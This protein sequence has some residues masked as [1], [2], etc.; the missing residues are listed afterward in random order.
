MLLLG[1]GTGADLPLLQ[2]DENCTCERVYA[3][4]YSS[5]MVKQCRKRARECGIP[6]DNVMQGDAQDLPFEEGVVFDKVL[7]PLS[8]GS[9]PQPEEAMR[10]ALRVLAPGGRVCVLEKLVDSNSTPS[11]ARK[12]IGCVTK[13]LFSDINRSLEDMLVLTPELKVVEYK[14]MAGLISGCF[15]MSADKYR[16]AVLVRRSDYPDLTEVE[17]LL[18]T[19]QTSAVTP[20]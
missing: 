11:C 13:C 20:S 12:M 3:L 18:V 16:V 19:K 2:S 17:T 9:I 14:S 7:F 6:V 8:L 15:G 1:E 10:E 5:Q 4:D